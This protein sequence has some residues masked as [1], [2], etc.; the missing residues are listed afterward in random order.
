M[1]DTHENKPKPAPL[2][3]KAL[4]MVMRDV[5]SGMQELASIA[6]FTPAPCEFTIL[7]VAESEPRPT[8]PDPA[9]VLPYPTGGNPGR[10]ERPSAAERGADIVDYLTRRESQAKAI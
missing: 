10:Q 3:D 2:A 9:P 4:E 7:P 1:S 6:A 8:Y 5:L